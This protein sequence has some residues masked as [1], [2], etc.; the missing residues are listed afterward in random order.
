MN[1]TTSSGR[2]RVDDRKDETRRR[3]SEKLQKI[4]E[5]R[6]KAERRKF[7]IRRERSLTPSLCSSPSPTEP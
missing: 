3:R 7:R 2:K 1:M 5:K 4:R 6:T